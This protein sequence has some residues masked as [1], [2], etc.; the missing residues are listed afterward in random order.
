MLHPHS[1]TLALK[2]STLPWV[3]NPRRNERQDDIFVQ[4]AAL[5]PTLVRCHRR[6]AVQLATVDGKCEQLVVLLT[7]E[8]EHINQRAINF[9]F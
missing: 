1:R 3:L 6:E 8:L 7:L 9:T 2:R 4:L 5:W